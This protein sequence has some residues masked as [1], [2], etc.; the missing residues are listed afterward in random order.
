MKRTGFSMIEVVF[1]MV[2]I[3]IL[4]AVAIP[5]LVM[6]RND[7]CY[8]KL[9]VNLSEAQSE[10]TRTYTKKFMQGQKMT[11]AEFKQILDDTLNANTSTGCGFTINNKDDI[12]MFV[13]SGSR[14]QTLQLKVDSNTSTN[15]PA[16]TCDTSVES[17]RKLTGKT[18]KNKKP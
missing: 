2:I 16:I 3:G 4:A 11:D 17:C 6:G 12:K 14:A 1:V 8:A 5:K 13:G 10:L 15:S 7:A 9:R 18:D